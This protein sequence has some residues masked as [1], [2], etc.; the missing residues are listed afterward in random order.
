VTPWSLLAIP[1]A[2]LLVAALLVLTSW[3][4]ESVLCPRSVI[5]HAVRSR[6]ATPDLIE[7]LVVQQVAPLLGE[8]GVHRDPF[9]SPPGQPWPATRRRRKA[10]VGPG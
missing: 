6:G 8:R 10:T 2:L 4:E 3:L 7:T 1:A 9:G 5:E